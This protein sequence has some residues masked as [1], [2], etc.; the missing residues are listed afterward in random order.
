[1]PTAEYGQ[2]LGLDLEGRPELIE[3]P[4]VSLLVYCE[5]WRRYGLKFGT[6]NYG[7]AIGNCINR[8]N[9]YFK[10]EPIGAGGRGGVSLLLA[11]SAAARI[12]QI[13]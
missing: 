4:A 9:A 7:R 5:I 8:G 10:H 2:R 6:H 11:C 13:H 12:C 1:M 3:N